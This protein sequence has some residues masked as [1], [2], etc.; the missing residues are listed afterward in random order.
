MQMRHGDLNAPI[1]HNVC[2]MFCKMK[3]IPRY[4]YTHTTSQLSISF[5]PIVNIGK[6]T[7]KLFFIPWTITKDPLD[8]F[9]PKL[10]QGIL[11]L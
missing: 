2:L 1:R 4:R 6:S 10:A 5:L 7:M 11:K 3:K 9:Q 8:K